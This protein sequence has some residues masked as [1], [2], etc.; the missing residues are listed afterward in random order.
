MPAKGEKKSTKACSMGAEMPHYCSVMSSSVAKKDG[1]VLR[2]CYD[3]FVTVCD[4][5]LGDG[6]LM[7]PCILSDLLLTVVVW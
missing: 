4:V 3:D 7:H 2:T 6:I 1:P 5:S